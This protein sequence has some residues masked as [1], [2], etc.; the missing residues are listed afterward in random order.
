MANYRTDSQLIE[1]CLAGD[2]QA[3]AL[4]VERY[5]RLVYSIAVRQGLSDE[6]AE[7][8]FQAVFAI[9]LDKLDTCR[10]RERLGSWLATIA[11]REAL[12]IAQQRAARADTADEELL[13]AH[14][15]SEPLPETVLEEMEE[16][17]LIRQGLERLGERCR[18]LL[19]HLFYQPEPLS[20]AR[21]ARELAI[22][23]GSIG[24]TR[25]RCLERLRSILADLGF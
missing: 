18:R 5:Q 1:A 3:W 14:P 11:R 13:D 25:A 24:P 19:Q 9:L 4:L 7:D 21:I 20:Y 10:K 22:P 23:E 2:E 8:A 6:D 16:Q 15:A 17:N 12:R